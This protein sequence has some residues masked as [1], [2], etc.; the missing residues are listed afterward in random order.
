M[1]LMIHCCH[2]KT[3]STLASVFFPGVEGT[4]LGEGSRCCVR[5]EVV[6]LEM[7]LGG[8]CQAHHGSARTG[9]H[10]VLLSPLADWAGGEIVPG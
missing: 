6:K 3:I 4:P 5:K 2:P 1:G 10:C 9:G 8:E 7:S